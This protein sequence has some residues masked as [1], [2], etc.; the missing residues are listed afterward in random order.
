MNHSFFHP[1]KQYGETLPVFDHEWEAIAF[2]YDY[3]QSQTE[4]L[5]ELCQFFNISL[6]YSPGSLLAVEALYFRSIKSCFWRIG[7]CRLTNLRK[8]SVCMSSIAPSDIMTM[9][10]GSSNLIRIRTALIR[11]VCG[12]ETKRGT[13][14]TAANIYIC[15]RRGSSAYRRL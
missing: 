8:C 4:E 11:R 3:R 14:T 7:T 9:P 1:E 12:E 15:K 2:Y 5:K 10:N 6:D 13:P